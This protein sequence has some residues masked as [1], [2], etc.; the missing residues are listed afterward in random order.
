MAN[1]LELQ[2]QYADDMDKNGI[3]YTFAVGE[4]FVESMRN[5]RYDHTGTAIDELIDNAI[6]ASANVISIAFGFEKKGIKSP[7]AIAIIDNGH[8][9]KPN[10]LRRAAAW[11]GT[12]RHA[13]EKREGMGRFGFG[14][15]SASVNQGRRFTIYSKL[16][17]GDWNSVTVDLDDIRDHKYSPVP[18]KVEVPETSPDNLPHWVVENIKTNFPAG[19]LNHGTVVVWEKLDRLSWSTSTGLENNLLPHFGTNY[20]NYLSQTQIVLNNTQIVAVDP[21]FI[22]PGARFYDE[23]ALKAASLGS[24]DVIV[25]SKRTGNPCTV[26]VR[27]ASIPPGF[28]AKDPNENLRGFS[29][30]RSRVKSQNL[31]IIICRMGRQIDVIDKVSVQDGH[32][33]WSGLGRLN[34]NDDRYWGLEIDF[35]ADLDEEFT[36]ANTKQGV[37]I[38]DRI[39]ELLKDDGVVTAVKSMRKAYQ[40]AVS[41]KAKETEQ[42]ETKLR[43]SEIAAKK[44][45]EQ[46][47][48]GKVQAVSPERE[49]QAKKNFEEFFKNEAKQRRIPESEAKVQA[50]EEA[51]KRPYKVEFESMPDAPF[52]RM[53][54]RGPMK[55]LHVNMAHRFYKDIYASP[56]ATRFMRNA[57]EVVLI[58]IGEGE[59]D[60]IGNVSKES[61]YHVE[62]LEWSKKMNV[63]LG[64][65]SEFA[66]VVDDEAA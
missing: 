60:A 66:E 15:P 1:Q 51:K 37:I 11:G 43:P 30:A 44:G 52:F 21:L 62:K 3:D 6:E 8:G 48:P 5:T 46:T 20:R 16:Q 39:W 64:A 7:N 35:P 36:I 24:K 13:A 28:Y 57:L 29:N 59:L 2:I 58:S 25:K 22:T 17:G 49:E 12:H 65:L 32:K 42:D 40:D 26:K 38:S 53:E 50:E 4:A 47:K 19:E 45:A 33:G 18:G 63:M 10:M 14:L 55:V 41:K 9:M 31:G 34:G 23:N 56:S 61:F 27:Y 54:Q